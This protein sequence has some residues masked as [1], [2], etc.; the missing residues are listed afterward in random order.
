MGGKRT[1]AE[2]RG[3][4]AHELLHTRHDSASGAFCT[5][6]LLLLPSKIAPASDPARLLLCSVRLLLVTPLHRIRQRPFVVSS[7][8][9]HTCI[10]RRYHVH[11]S[12][13]LPHTQLSLSHS[14]FD[15]CVYTGH[16]I[17]TSLLT[18]SRGRSRRAPPGTAAW[19]NRAP[20]ATRRST[21]P[22][23]APLAAL[24]ITRS[25]SDVA[26]VRR[27]SRRVYVFVLLA[28]SFCISCEFTVLLFLS[29]VAFCST[30]KKKAS[31]RL[32]YLCSFHTYKKKPLANS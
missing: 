16:T 28:S 7:L 31:R 26:R 18:R 23:A 4:D 17:G 15:L 19:A 8:R 6:P 2:S 32:V 24:R 11:N 21:S 5:Y 14:P 25:A 27:S 20:S 9:A 3:S 22:S 1:R 30:W 12:L 29:H 13:S 10:L